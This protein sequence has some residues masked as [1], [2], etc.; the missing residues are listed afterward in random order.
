MEFVEWT[1]EA[2]CVHRR[3]RACGG[4]D[5]EEVT[6]RRRRQ[7]MA[8]EIRKGKRV[9]KLSNLDKPFW[10]EEG[11]TKGDL[12]AYYR[13]VA[14]V[15]PAPQGPSVHDEA[16]SRRGAGQV[17]LPE[18][19]AEAHAGL[20]QDRRVPRPT[21]EEPRESRI[22]KP[23]LSATSRPAL[24]GEHGLYRPEHVVFAGRQ[25]RAPDSALFD[26][27]PSPDVGF[28]ETVEVALLVKQALHTLGLESFPK[29]S[30]AERHPRT[31]SDRPPLHV[32]RTREFSAIIAGRWRATP[33]A[34]R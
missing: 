7:P 29:T 24:D 28:Q 8:T 19:R 34:R 26:L 31:R 4:Q 30:G 20:D 14:R 25:S 6:G 13:G 16:L 3:T 22:I 27:D 5:A 1:H 21:R 11:I 12:L 17:L 9:L 2:T 18:G 23:R 10:P 15:L 32:L 33:R